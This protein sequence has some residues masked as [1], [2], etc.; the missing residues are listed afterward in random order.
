VDVRIIAA[1]NKQIEELV[2]TG[3]FREDLYF[4]LN[5]I[6]IRIPPLRERREDIMPLTEYYLAEFSREF[7]RPVQGFPEGGRAWMASHYWPGNVR[8]LKNAIERMIILGTD[9]LDVTRDFGRTAEKA[10]SD[11][12]DTREYDPI[13]MVKECAAKG[14]EEPMAQ[15]QDGSGYA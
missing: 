12:A 3:K 13:P 2:K 14:A 7:K 6:P 11:Q 10:V 1:T 8:E 9:D 4:R 5:V 15:L